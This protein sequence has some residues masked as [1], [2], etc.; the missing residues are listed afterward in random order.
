MYLH[1]HVHTRTCIHVTSGLI[2]CCILVNYLSPLPLWPLPL[3]CSRRKE[4]KLNVRIL[5]ISVYQKLV[6]S[7]SMFSTGM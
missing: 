6:M 7:A 2:E 5:L 1:L 3:L 4:S